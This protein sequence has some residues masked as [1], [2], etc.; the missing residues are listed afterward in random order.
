MNYTKRSASLEESQVLGTR[1]ATSEARLSFS[2]IV[3]WVFVGSIVF[4]GGMVIGIYLIK[5]VFGI[6]PRWYFYCSALVAIAFPVL[7]IC[8]FLKGKSSIVQY[9][10]T[11]IR[12]MDVEEMLLNVDEVVAIDD[13]VDGHPTYCYKVDDMHIIVLRGVEDYDY[14]GD[15]LLTPNSSFRIVRDR[16]S[17]VILRIDYLGHCLRP[18][19]ILDTDIDVHKNIDGEV[20]ECDWDLL[21]KGLVKI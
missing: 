9:E 8:A 3:M 21:K 18:F 17:K 2:T 1:S 4:T 14:C 15:E 16:D 6:L 20:F 12:C 10:A 13:P 19:I 11:S 5:P 7:R